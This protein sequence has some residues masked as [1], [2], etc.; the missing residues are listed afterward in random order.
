MHDKGTHTMR[1]PPMTVYRKESSDGLG[2]G[3]SVEI[4]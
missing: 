4:P 2:F 3:G 1:L